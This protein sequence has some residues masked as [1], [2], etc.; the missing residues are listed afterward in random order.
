MFIRIAENIFF[1]SNYDIDMVF[2][3]K[4]FLL[5]AITGNNLHASMNS[6]VAFIELV[7]FSL[8][9]SHRLVKPAV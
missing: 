6:F 5:A 7:A 8:H 1:Y 2:E 9:A 3:R 4:K